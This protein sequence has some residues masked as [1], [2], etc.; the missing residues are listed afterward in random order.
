[1]L[2]SLQC[3]IAPP[4]SMVPRLQYAV[5]PRLGRPFRDADESSSAL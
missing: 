5:G 4:T 2:N 1:M 3:N